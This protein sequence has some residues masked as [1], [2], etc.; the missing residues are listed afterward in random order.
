[1]YRYILVLLTI[2]TQFLYA[3]DKSW[4]L[5]NTGNSSLP[6]ETVK[7]I[8][9]DSEGA[10]WVG[11]YMGGLAVLKNNVW[12][13]YNTS[14]S[15]LPH[16]YINSIAI[17]K[18]NVKWI[19][20]DGGGLA[21]FD[22]TSWQ[23]FKTSTSGLPSNVVMSV[24]CDS[25]GILW[26]GTYFGGLARFDGQNWTVYNDENSPLLSNKI[27][28]IEKD[29]NDRLW[30][31]TQGGGL[32]SFD[33]NV[34]TIYSE[35]NSKLTS[36]YIYSIAIDKENNKWVGTGGGGVAVF[37]DVFWISYNSKNSKIADDNIRPIM[38][39]ENGY[40][41]IGTYIGGVNFF[42]SAEWK[43]FDYQNSS[44][45]DD[46]VTCLAYKHPNLFIGTERFG[47]VVFQ[48]NSAPKPSK[49][50]EE[51]A[52]IVTPPVIIEDETAEVE[53]EQKEIPQEPILIVESKAINIEDTGAEI[54]S[55]QKEIPQEPILIA[56]SQA[57]NIEDTGAE[58]EP[59]QKEIPQEP[60]LIVESQAIN[61]EDTGAEIEPE[62][63]E[64]PQ[65]PILIVES[66]AINIED[67]GAEIESEQKE[68]PQEPI[69]IVESQ[70]INIEDTGAEIE[71]EQKEIPQEPILVVESQ[72]INIEDAGAEIEPEQKEIPQEPILVVESNMINTVDTTT[73]VEPVQKELPQ[74]LIQISDV[75]TRN[76]IVLFFD[77]ADVFF[78]KSRLNMYR[79]SFKLLL[80]NRDRINDTYDVTLLIY[81]SNYELSPKKIQFTE[82]DMKVLRV[83]NIIYLEGET[84]FT[85]AVKKAFANI[86]EEY[87]SYGSNQ[88]IAA[89]YKFINDDETAKV[90]IK[91]YLDNYNIVFSLLAYETSNWEM[92]YKMQD[93]VPKG[94]SRY[95]SINHLNIKDNWSVTGQ[96]GLSMFRG[97]L[98]V[99]S[100]IT[101]PGEY[102][103]A[104]NK[105]VLST[106]ILN[107]GIKGQ[108]NFGH[109]QGSKNDYSF[110]NK[111][112]EGSINF[113]VILNTWV[114]RNFRF[115]KVRPYAF[116]G[117]GFINYRVLIRDPN[118]YVVNGYGY[119]I[120][121]GDIEGNGKNPE[122][123]KPVT[124]LMIP[125]GVGLNYKLNKKINLELEASS[126][127][128][129]SDKL[130][131]KVNGK[132]DKYWFVSLG[133]T[134]MFSNK[135]FIADILNR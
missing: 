135:E 2:I 67:T 16:N 31:G 75:K 40:K 17:D 33:G 112:K 77:A 41:W 71:S 113:Q 57:I 115:E 35:K 66:Q 18:N 80:R 120:V 118:G 90:V 58:I 111:Y 21:K 15:E 48:D 128:I 83:K 85:E 105:Q 59:E 55:E 73:E 14:N 44:M 119:K 130:D 122:K 20:T 37:N 103:I 95:Y 74:E 87:N 134:Y 60:I 52:I 76:K 8:V 13:V 127:F 86:E 51:I 99:N 123:D 43:V 64:I 27:V 29:T 132:N 100:V 4:S 110:E 108:F 92:E 22:G 93:I 47:I 12:T 121:D 3:Q 98:D 45:P 129:N 50:E 101:F 24:Y 26:I 32:G 81:S 1:M 124:D 68:I 63:K 117:I 84:Q 25:N 97:D 49:I 79:R 88:V 62:Q 38:V 69:L 104:L 19:G 70:A 91:E 7:C 56:E 125:V 114:D 54:E 9:F 116:T 46:E 96:I 36:D 133:V 42:N 72:A 61:I 6:N 107:G 102:G 131:G 82:R 5:I 11:T 23:V 126:R 78:D 106:G 89:T 109:L 28:D 53:P 39:D 34:W 30:V 10:M 65:E 94:S